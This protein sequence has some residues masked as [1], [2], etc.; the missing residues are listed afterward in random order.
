[1]MFISNSCIRAYEYEYAGF[2]TINYVSLKQTGTI[3]K[4]ERKMGFYLY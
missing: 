3:S 4:K 2:S 1:M